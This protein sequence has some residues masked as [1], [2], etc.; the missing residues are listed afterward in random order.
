M[1][2]TDFTFKKKKLIV[3]G[4]IMC[5]DNLYIFCSKSTIYFTCRCKLNSEVAIIIWQTIECVMLLV[6]IIW[7][8]FWSLTIGCSNHAVWVYC[9]DYLCWYHG[10]WRG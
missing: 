1:G 2:I 10:S 3:K 4:T 9:L 7:I 6:C 8:F 5:P